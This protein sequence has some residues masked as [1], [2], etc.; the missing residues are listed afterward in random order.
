MPAVIVR[1]QGS[2]SEHLRMFDVSTFT[3][4]TPESSK[5]CRAQCYSTVAPS[6]TEA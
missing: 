5:V 4:R 6:D 3:T 2:T 1:H